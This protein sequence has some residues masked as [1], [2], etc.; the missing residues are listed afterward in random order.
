MK[1]PPVFA[2]V[3]KLMMQ[4]KVCLAVVKFINDRFL[5]IFVTF[6]ATVEVSLFKHTMPPAGKSKKMLPHV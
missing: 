4:I 6:F 5:P 1:A 3:K 2:Y